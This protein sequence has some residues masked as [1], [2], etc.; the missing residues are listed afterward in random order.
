[1]TVASQNGVVGHEDRISYG[2]SKA[3]L[4]QLSKNLTIDFAKYSEKDIRINSISPSYV[5]TKENEESYFNTYPGKKMLERIP[6]RTLV[7]P[8]EVAALIDFLLSKKCKSIR[9]QNIIID[10]GYTII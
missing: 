9:G 1:V 10:N 3:A 7:P 6:T 2:T 8:H 4:I 5:H